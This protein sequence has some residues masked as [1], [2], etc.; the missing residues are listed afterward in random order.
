MFYH[1]IG[2]IVKKVVISLPQLFK[3]LYTM[4]KKEILLICFGIS[5]SFASLAQDTLKIMQYNLLYYG[6]N[7][8]DCNSTNNNID[9][10]NVALRTIIEHTQPDIFCVNEMDASTSDVNY[11]MDNVLNIDGVTSWQHANLTGSFSVNML[12]Y[13]SEK[14]TLNSQEYI[15][16]SP[17][18][19]NV[20]HLTHISEAIDFTVF[21]AHLKAGAASD[22]QDDRANATIN[23]MNYI[24]NRGAGN[25]IF[26][27][28]LN[29][30]Y[31]SEQAFQNLTTVTSTEFA[32]FDPI[33]RIGSWHNSSSFS[34]V[35]TQAT[36]TSGDCFVTG[37]MD[38]RFD[39]IMISEKI[40]DGENKIQYLTNSY[41]TVG[42]D[43]NHFNDALIDGTNN[44]APSNV[45]SALYNMSDHLPVSLE[46]VFGVPNP[47][48]TIFNKTFNDQ[49]LTS[50]GWTEYSVLDAARIWNIPDNTYGH[51]STYYI[52]MSGYDSGNNVAVDN[53]DWL[54]S[55]SF[56]ANELDDEILTFWTAGKYSGNDL[57]AYYSLDYTE[58][59]D[60]N[61]STWVE[62]SGFNLSTTADYTWETSGNIDIS[63]ILGENVRIGFKYTSEEN[64]GSRT[65]QID[66]ILLVG[67]DPTAT[68]QDL[69]P[70]NIKNLSVFPNPTK[71][72]INVS[73]SLDFGNKIRL[74]VFNSAGI[75]VYSEDNLPNKKG[76]HIHTLESSVKDLPTGMYFFKISDKEGFRTVKLI[77]E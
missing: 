48:V 52:K 53:E 17:R 7:V 58:G 33:N 23:V 44:S 72:I 76:T 36:H 9:D 20:Y 19:T 64:T 43:G 54:I 15:T 60:P 42:Q 1:L 18:Q 55:P 77:K 11:L 8:Y 25:Y 4:F 37:G 12:Y 38:D 31:S 59:E 74:Q 32:F 46:L 63:Q 66:D 62:L 65:W 34:D 56:N 51:N 75:L 29:I 5:L 10:K 13:N 45:I 39:F 71:E 28:D 41:E 24:E 6:K 69:K 73:Y 67:T 50:G 3:D 68:V 14:F 21:V 40:K 27:G 57:Q 16:A 30:Y 2:I 70:S 35:H 49:S 26:M 22:D 47:P 61:V